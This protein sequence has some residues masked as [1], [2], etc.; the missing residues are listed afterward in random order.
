MATEVSVD[1]VN[2]SDLGEDV[3]DDFDEFSEAEDDKNGKE[4]EQIGSDESRQLS[5]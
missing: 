4:C 5:D 1:L 3:L 2:E